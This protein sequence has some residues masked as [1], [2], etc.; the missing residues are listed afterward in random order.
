MNEARRASS[1]PLVSLARPDSAAS[2]VEPARV[3]TLDLPLPGRLARRPGSSY[4]SRPGRVS[5]GTR[6]GSS[7]SED[8]DVP[9]GCSTSACGGARHE[10]L[11]AE[12]GSGK[13]SRS[14]RPSRRERRGRRLDRSAVVRRPDAVRCGPAAT[15]QLSLRQRRK[16]TGT[17]GSPDGPAQAM[18][19]EAPGR[20][21]GGRAASRRR[22][23]AG[24]G[25]RRRAGEGAQAIRLRDRATARSRPASICDRRR[26]R[27]RSPPAA[28]GRSGPTRPACSTLAE[29]PLRI[30]RHRGD[31]RAGRSHGWRA[32]CD[33]SCAATNAFCLHL[34]RWRAASTFSATPTS[35]V[36]RMEELSEQMQSSQ[37]VAWAD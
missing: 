27:R 26:R 35:S 22:G 28:A 25:G 12:V 17:S 15:A 30:V 19:R 5:S 11:P 16:S 8:A 4:W 36:A 33:R 20:G 23:P 29:L 6:A 1:S 3:A 24:G 21:R 32:K 31:A 13:A 7:L 14:A 34:R 37:R 18:R 10:R 9:C 2:C